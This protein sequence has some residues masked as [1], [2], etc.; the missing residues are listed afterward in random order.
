MSDDKIKFYNIEAEHLADLKKVAHR[1][2]STTTM[3]TD[4]MR[5]AAV[6]IMTVVNYA[7]VL[8]TLERPASPRKRTWFR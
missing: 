8:D 1:L 6:K 3:N 7:E 2:L 4:E 5:D